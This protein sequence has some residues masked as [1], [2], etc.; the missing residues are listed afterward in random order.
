MN[1]KLVFAIGLT[2]GG[3]AGVVGSMFFWKRYFSKKADE[4]IEQFFEETNEYK[5]TVDSYSADEEEKTEVSDSRPEPN[6]D[7]AEIKRRLEYNNAQTTNY[8]AMYSSKDKLAELTDDEIE[9]LNAESES[10]SEEDEDEV[11]FSQMDDYHNKNK[12]RDPR[13][14][15]EDDIGDLPNGYSN[16]TLFLYTFDKILVDEDDNEVEDAEQ[17]IGNCLEK[18]GFLYSDERIIFVQNF[19]L[20]TVY[21]IQKIDA[22]WSEIGK[23]R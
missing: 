20:D 11:V 15:S 12:N 14:I 2:I 6:L 10:P 8:A 17:I 18:Y 9:E 23:T 21:E 4:K 7:L 1:N 5:R 3:A 16:E 22:A 19:K 13:I